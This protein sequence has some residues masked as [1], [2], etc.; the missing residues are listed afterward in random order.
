MYLRDYLQDIPL[1]ALKAIA[2]ALGISVEYCARIKL[3]NAID[4][5]FWGGTLVE[6]LVKCLSEDH[7]HVLTLIAFSYSTGIEEN[8]LVRK[9]ERYAGL[10]RKRIIQIIND[11]IPLALVGGICDDKTIYFCPADI[12]EYI[13]KLILADMVKYPDK[14]E[15][16]TFVAQP[17]LLEDIFS[18]L[19]RIYK[20]EIPLTLKGRVR[21]KVLEQIFE[22]SLT[23]NDS[24]SYFS[25]AHR[26]SFVIEY[27][28]KRNLVSF[29]H[30]V[31]R[32]TQELSGWL[33]L[34]VTQRYQDIIS[35]ALSHVLQDKATIIIVSGFLTEMPAGSSFDIQ[36]I[37]HFLN[38][39]TIASGELVKL[40][41]RFRDFLCI[42]SQMAL[43]SFKNGMCV[44]TITGER[45]F[46]GEKL[47]GDDVMGNT[48]T[49]QPNFEVIVGPEI[50]PK[51]R[52]ILEL[53]ALRKS[54]DT[55]L[56]YVVNQK[57]IARAR[58]HGMSIEDIIGFFNRH[59]R[60][61]IPQ[62]IR[63]SIENWAKSYGSVFFEQI[64]LMR[65]RDEATC[66]SV[67]H[68]PEIAPYIIERLSKTALV[69][70]SKYIPAITLKLKKAGYLPQ[71]FG[72]MPPDPI[73]NGTVF[74]PE[75]ITNLTSAHSIPE[76]DHKYVFFTLIPDLN[77][78]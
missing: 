14:H 52:F 16:G 37:S 49:V 78:S 12:A 20:A 59:S 25:E 53:L 13:R 7:L 5:A 18:F 38:T 60:N 57:G 21:K 74:S 43:V 66:D 58:E 55:V 70:S 8:I 34:P 2:D 54:R 1:K 42:C 22:G 3:M 33:D 63:F 68:S 9:I 64:T 77:V 24:Q 11:L 69:I 73:L 39:E 51:V 62:N 41:S 17:N 50:E 28:K 19:A 27:L 71:L 61:T 67:L 76:I 72:D 35:F 10:N 15:T 29:H 56:T 26:N 32:V 45:F 30:R 75:N 4:R 40:S 48:F 31:A 47:P 36:R 23:C 6:N 65:F 44:M 46:H